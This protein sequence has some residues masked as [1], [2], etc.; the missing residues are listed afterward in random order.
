MCTLIA[1]HRCVDRAGLL[2]AANRDEFY[3]RPASGP[4]LRATPSGPIVAPLDLRAGGT[5]LG[6]N[7]QGVFAALTN[8]PCTAPDPTRRSRGH[9][10]MEALAAPTAEQAA[11]QLAAIPAAVHNPFNVFVAD[12]HR[13][14]ALVYGGD[15]AG[16]LRE[17]APGA[18]VVGNADPDDRTNPKVARVLAR[19]EAAAGFG[20][21][22]ALEALADACREQGCGSPHGA[23][24]DTCVHTD[25]YGTRSSLLL[26]LARDGARASEEPFGGDD[27]LL[28]ADGAPCTTSYLDF[29]PLLRELTQRARYA[30][31]RDHGRKAQ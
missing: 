13:A 27:R 16:E 24:G 21:D 5:W 12:G 30:R 26:R 15:R 3:E 19:A 29:T 6:V 20:A 23:L 4:A 28:F 7:A 25:G 8:R 10:V 11:E 14:F 17:L 22:A 2:I 31:G 1:L 18:H 9:V